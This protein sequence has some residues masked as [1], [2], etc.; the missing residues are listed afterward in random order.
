LWR[1]QLHSASAITHCPSGITDAH[2][3]KIKKKYKKEKSRFSDLFPKTTT[4]TPPRQHQKSN[5]FKNDAFKKGTV[6][7][8]RRRPIMG[9]LGFH[10]EESPRS[11]NNAFN[12]AIIKHNQLRPDLGFLP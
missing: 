4:L 9:I 7:M 10:P 3:Q 5:F 11:R 12:K 2:S 6:H 1:Y 8:R